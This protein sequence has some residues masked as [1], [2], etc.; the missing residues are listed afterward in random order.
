MRGK[1]ASLTRDFL[2]NANRAV[3]HSLN[4]EAPPRAPPKLAHDSAAREHAT[5]PRA[6]SFSGAVK[7]APDALS[8]YIAPSQDCVVALDGGR[9]QI[10]DLGDAGE[11]AIR[12]RRSAPETR[13]PTGEAVKV[14]L[15]DCLACSGC[16]TSA[17]SVLLE[18]QSVDEVFERSEAFAFDGSRYCRLGSRSHRRERES[19][20]TVQPR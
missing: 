11:V 19:A 15:S 16:V 2:F 1:R 9:V 5:T 6:M 18:Q 10:D 4:V 3:E 13:A 20:V 17:E 12:S 8:D 14:T 7:I